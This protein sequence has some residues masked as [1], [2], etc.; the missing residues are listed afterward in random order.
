VLTPDDLDAGWF[1][2]V[3]QARYP[4]TRVASAERTRVHEW[5]NLHVHVS[6]SYDENP[7]GAPERVFIK[8]PPADA[9]KGRG[10][11]AA[12]MGARE[13]NFYLRLAPVIDLRVPT[14][15]G[16]VV[17]EDG[18]FAIVIE[19]LY[20]TGCKTLNLIPVP[21]DVAARALA[22]LARMHVRYEEPGARAS[23]EVAWI[24][25]PPIPAPGEQPPPNLG[26]KLL[27]RGIDEQADRLGEAYVTIAEHW[28]EDGGFFQRV[29]WD[30]PH[31][32]I[33]NDAHPGNLFDDHGRI[34]F[35]DW[36]LVTVGDPMRDVSYFLCLSLDPEVRRARGADL[37]RHYLD[38]RRELGGRPIEFDDA[39]ARLRLHAAYTVP[40]S[41]Q[42][43]VAPAGTSERGRR[44]SDLFLE[45]AIAAV[46]D[47]D[48][49]AAFE[50]ARK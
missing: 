15:H 22:D 43:L 11:G 25:P 19:D 44:F 5:T 30:A 17:E 26:Q 29:W 33:H 46:T 4:G 21:S 14:P 20:A 1:T 45:R 23:E 50:E 9:A 49:P 34:G 8:L 24:E 6:L 47:L 42:A 40:A 48:A 39:W 13:A 7:A 36:G 41:C 28:I 32:V 31:T 18:G 12:R 3:L 27:R 16:A 38:V 2:D 37:L 10:L 35:F